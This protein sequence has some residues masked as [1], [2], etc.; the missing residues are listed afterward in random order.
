MNKQLLFGC[1]AAFAASVASAA[2][3][4]VAAYGAVRRHTLIIVSGISANM[5]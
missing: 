1:F 2:T 5:I 3:F 4:D